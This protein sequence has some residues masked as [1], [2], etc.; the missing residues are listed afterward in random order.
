MFIEVAPKS[1]KPPSRAVEA[2]LVVAL[3]LLRVV[4]H[5]VGF[6]SLLELLLSLFVARV[7]VGMVFDGYLTIRFLDLVL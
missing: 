5:V 1:P 2:K 6:G 3:A 4:E 7:T